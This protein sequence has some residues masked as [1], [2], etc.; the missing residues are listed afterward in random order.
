MKKPVL[1]CKRTW[2]GPR[3]H[4]TDLFCG[5]GG[6]STGLEEAGYQLLLASNHDPVSLATHRANHPNAEHWVED[7]NALDKRRLPRTPVLWASPI[8]TEISPAGGRKRSHGQV[9]FDLTG[10]GEGGVARQETFERTRTTALDILAATEVHRYL[11][12][13]CENVLEFA[14]DWELFDWWLRGMEILGYNYQIVCASSAHLGSGSNAPAPQLRDRVYVVFTRKD[15]PLPDLEVRPRAL[16]PE[17][18]IVEARQVWRNPDRR[19]IGKYGVQ[20]DYRCPNRACGHL[21]IEPITR[22]VSDIIEWDV[23][24]QRIGDGKPNRRKFTPYAASTRARV[25]TGLEKFAD[26]PRIALFQRSGVAGQDINHALVVPNGRK[27]AVRTTAEPMT[28]IATRAH[29]TLV[30]PALE[31]D[32]CT[33]RMFTTGELMRGQ[34][35][36]EGYI[37]LGTDTEQKLQAGNAVSV[38][39][40]RWLG[41][42]VMPSLL[43]FL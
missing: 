7:I 4:F 2:L 39:A 43:A 1:P 12:I 34:R 16:C 18:G 35:F 30:R 42:R 28:T 37:V 41:E 24:G 5:A 3:I 21:I 31:V 13:F 15:V 20:Y 10:T 36:P 6:S 26:D 40:A 27:A 11:V 38:N 17:C 22:P 25:A 23:A 33:L 8:C 19:R 32:D 14:T 9:A 29:H